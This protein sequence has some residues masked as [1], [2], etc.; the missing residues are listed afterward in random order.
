MDKEAAPGEEVRLEVKAEGFP[1][2]EV[3]WFKNS[4]P[5]TETTEKFTI[6]VR[7][8]RLVFHRYGRRLRLKHVKALTKLSVNFLIHAPTI[9]KCII[10]IVMLSWFIKFTDI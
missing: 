4:E 1:A 9:R 6:T 10:H 8:L 7:L 2:P 3:T 5:I